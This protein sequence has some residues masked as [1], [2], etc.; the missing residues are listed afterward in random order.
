[1]C[2]VEE[3]A[4]KIRFNIQSFK[5]AGQKVIGLCAIL[6]LPLKN[7]IDRIS[8]V[9]ISKIGIF[10]VQADQLR[11]VNSDFWNSSQILSN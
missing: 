5:L 8:K 7:T 4:L 10:L 11:T 3:N 2:L 9:C 6:K 1:L